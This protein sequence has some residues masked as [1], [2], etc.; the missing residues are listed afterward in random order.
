MSDSSEIDAAVSS[1][2]IVPRDK[3]L[4]WIESADDLTS[5]AGLYKLTGDGYYRIQ[6][7]LGK[8][9][10]CTAVRKYLLECVRQNVEH[11]DEIES[12]WEASRTL[13]LWLRRLHEL[14]GC[15]DEIEKTAEAITAL[16]LSSGEEIRLAIEQGFLEH[17]L[18]SGGLRPYFEEWQKDE[19]LRETWE[20]AMA[21]AND[22]PDWSW[23]MHQELQAKISKE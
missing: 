7:E 23:N 19:R 4:R 12:R 16:F 13:H 18:E 22:H 20:A 8:E 3:V 9:A 11:D 14:G 5:L 10:A 1:D 6:P 2:G 15:S 21:W 17:A